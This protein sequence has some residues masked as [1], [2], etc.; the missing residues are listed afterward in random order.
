MDFE[1]CLVK[2]KIEMVKHE[3][4]TY[5][6]NKGANVE[7]I[8]HQQIEGVNVKQIT[9]LATKKGEMCQ[10]TKNKF[11]GCGLQFIQIVQTKNNLQNKDWIQIRKH[12]KIIK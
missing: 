1:K 11:Q 6:Q 7:Q 9:N 3:Q 5:Q 12:W 10:K 8:V 4:I 2:H